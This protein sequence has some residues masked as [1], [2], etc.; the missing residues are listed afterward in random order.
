MKTQ[1]VHPSFSETAPTIHQVDI[2]EPLDW[3][4]AGFRTL[5]AARA[6]SLVYGALFTLA[7][8]ATLGLTW[9][10]PWFT[11]A[12]VTG[13]LLLGPFLAAG[14]YVAARQHEAGVPVSIRAGFEL[15]WERRTNLSLFALL[16]GLIAAA[17]VRLSA[18][19]FAVQ[20]NMFS[21]SI[22]GYVG[23][24]SGHFDPVV[25]AF[26]F[27]IGLLL[28]AVV[29]TISAV[30]VPMILDRDA[31]PITAMQTSYRAVRSNL[32]AMTLWA[33]LIVAV[34]GIGILTFFVGMVVLFP[35]LGYATW[36]SYR[37]L[38]A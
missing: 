34:S 26:F 23:I 5:A 20:F 33:A 22:E 10:L 4:A 32:S 31:G 8:W 19:L 7:C 17:W 37:R 36:H 38:V 27:G 3:I 12:F 14:L 21:P 24:L 29:F 28:A 1:T 35:L 30:A 18:L 2:T 9:A 25:M 16:L 11:I 15:V 6:C 13:L